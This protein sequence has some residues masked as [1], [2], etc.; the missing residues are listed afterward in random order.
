MS[1]ATISSQFTEATLDTI[2]RA[3]GGQRHTAWRF[4][5]GF[6]KGDSYLSEAYRLH[7]DGCRADGTPIHVRT[8]VK[9]I[10]K[11][12][13]R[14]LTFRCA[15]FYRNECNFYENILAAMHK[16]QADRI[17]AADAAAAAAAFTEVPRLL[18]CHC[19]GL[20]DFIALEDLCVDG[21]ASA[22]REQGV[23]FHLA[24]MVMRVM[25]KFHGVSLAIGDQDAALLK[26]LSQST[27]E[28]YCS[29]ELRNWYAPFA[30]HAIVVARDAMHQE[31]PDTE[32]ERRMLAFTDERFY[33]R[34][35]AAIERRNRYTAFGHGD[36]WL[37]NF[38][39]QYASKTAD[40]QPAGRAQRCKMIDFQLTRFASP[41][42]DLSIVLYACTDQQL[43][44]Q[45]FDDLLR[46]YHESACELIAAL[47]SD[48]AV[49]FP[50]SALQDELQAVGYFGVGF[51]MEAITMSVMPDDE[52]PD[53]DCLQGD[54]AVPL[55]DIWKIRKFDKQADRK[56][57][58]DVFRHA[59]DRGYLK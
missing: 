2:V 52:V 51:A 38:L 22:P 29:E 44:E 30:E 48:P 11:N 34:M 8:V 3:A 54:Q 32:Y 45:H 6:K 31:Y 37:P 58:A 50:W 24:A 9:V 7:I 46:I 1:L 47:G 19:D 20:N 36:C 40:G 14:R 43:R 42:I 33:D 49:C 41:A 18:C 23:D 13:V 35:V 39:M 28:V 53:L 57:M 56:R 10:P 27:M 25:G 59:I 17:A 55:T 26:R 15:D 21:Y 12:I 4:G 5:S 16:F